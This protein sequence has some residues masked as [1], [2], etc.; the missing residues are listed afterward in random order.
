MTDREAFIGAVKADEY[1]ELELSTGDTLI[2]DHEFDGAYNPYVEPTGDHGDA[3]PTD[4][5]AA[6]SGAIEEATGAYVEDIEYDPAND[7]FV[8][9]MDRPVAD[10]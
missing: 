10:D 7:V 6:I 2:T 9:Y 3:H 4:I 8:P 5:L 1:A